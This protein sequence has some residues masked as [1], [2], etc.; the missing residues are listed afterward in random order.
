M[1]VWALG[2]EGLRFFKC[3]ARLL[4]VALVEVR[5]PE[6]DVSGGGIRSGPHHFLEGGRGLGEAELLEKGHTPIRLA[7]GFA[8]GR[9]LGRRQQESTE[10]KE[11][12][13][14]DTPQKPWKQAIILW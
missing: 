2:R 11:R 7:A 13:F 5:D 10:E 3:F 4:E 6:V 12:Y 8:D 9:P 14:H 1:H